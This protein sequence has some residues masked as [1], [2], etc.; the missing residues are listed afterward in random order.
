[1]RALSGTPAP[2]TRPIGRQLCRLAPPHLQAK[3]RLSPGT[4][5]CH[6]CPAD[7]P[8]HQ[9]RNFEAMESQQRHHLDE[10][11]C[12]ANDG[13]RVFSCIDLPDCDIQDLPQ[14]CDTF[15]THCT[16]SRA[17]VCHALHSDRPA[18]EKVVTGGCS[19]LRPDCMEHFDSSSPQRPC[20]P[21]SRL[22]L[23]S[24]TE[25]RRCLEWVGRVLNVTP[26]CL[27]TAS[28]LHLRWRWRRLLQMIRKGW[29]SGQLVSLVVRLQP[30]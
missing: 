9:P 4:Q 22:H 18:T 1:M 19:C 10:P 6:R 26:G 25:Q 14:R 13:K 24:R 16:S 28:Q 2:A 5:P 15:A 17:F 20:P 27:S 7:L 30:T 23:S 8:T 21:L 11:S 12:E 29:L 3:L